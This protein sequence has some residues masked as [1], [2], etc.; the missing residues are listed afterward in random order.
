[1]LDNFDELV[2]DG[3]LTLAGVEAHLDELEGAAPDADPKLLGEY[4]ALASGGSS[5]RRGVFVYG[6]ADWAE[7]LAGIKALRHAR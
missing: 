6:A 1:M 5:G 3:R 7:V 4:R 2:T